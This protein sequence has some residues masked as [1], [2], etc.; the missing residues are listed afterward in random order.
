MKKT[1]MPLNLQF[2]A[3]PPAQ[4]PTPPAAQPP[5]Q[6][7]P[8]PA[9]SVPAGSTQLQQ[10][11]TPAQPAEKTFTQS[12]LNDIAARQKKEGREAVYKEL[13][14]PKEKFDLLKTI[15]SGDEV[16]GTPPNAPSGN[17]VDDLRMKT[18]LLE[19]QARAELALNG[20]KQEAVDD[21]QTLVVAGLDVT[22]YTLE[23][24]KEKVKLIQQRHTN[25]F[26]QQTTV[27][28]PVQ[29]GT[30]THLAGQQIAAPAQ[31]VAKPAQTPVSGLGKR[32]AD[33]R[34]GK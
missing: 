22:D 1:L 6:Q 25:S 26:G 34:K 21:M 9:Q 32:L 14:I 3:D 27:T 12:E 5:A 16:S 20:V 19:S 11:P 8:P 18:Q 4:E 24:I 28:E 15:L 29:Q 31:G 7:D 10:P 23:Q 13:G 30:G 33:Q 17:V 2:F